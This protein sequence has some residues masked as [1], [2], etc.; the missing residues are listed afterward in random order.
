MNKKYLSVLTALLIFVIVSHTGHQARAGNSMLTIDKHVLEAANILTR[1]IREFTR[2]GVPGPLQV[3]SKKAVPVIMDNNDQAV[4]AL[5]SYGKGFAIAMGHNAWL[6]KKMLN[7]KS[8][9]QFIQNCISLSRSR[10]PRIL[11]FNADHLYNSLKKT[12]RVYKTK[13]LPKKLSSYKVIFSIIPTR[14]ENFFQESEVSRIRKW[15]SRGGVFVGASIGWVFR[16]YGPGKKGKNITEDFIANKLFI[17]MGIKYKP[18]YAKGRN[19][20]VQPVSSYNKRIKKAHSGLFIDE[21]MQNIIKNKRYKNHTEART[22]IKKIFNQLNG[23][24]TVKWLLSDKEIKK[25]TRLF[26]KEKGKIFPTLKN[27]IDILNARQTGLILLMDRILRS[28]NYK[29]KAI[30]A[31]CRD[32]PGIAAESKSI[33]KD[34]TIDMSIPRWH[35]TGLWV[36]PYDKINISV[37]GQAVSKGL[38]IRIGCHKDNLFLSKRINIWERWPNISKSVALKSENNIVSSPYGGLI[39]IDV[40]VKL[41]GKVIVTIK[42]AAPAPLYTI[43]ETTKE[44]WQSQLKSTSSPIGEIQGKYVII[45][46]S[47][48]ALKK[49]YD[50]EQIARFWDSAILSIY[51]LA[52]TEPNPCPERYVI[53]QQLIA[54]YMHNGYPMV[55]SYKPDMDRYVLGFET[56]RGRLLEEGSWGHFHE[57]GHNNQ[58]P[59]WTFSGTVEVTVN[60][61][62]LY[63]MEK[64]MGIK[65]LEHKC[66]KKAMERKQKYIARGSRFSEWKK[67]P[68]L[69]LLMYIELQQKFGW[70][71][72]KKV[73]RLYNGLSKSERPKND[74]Q[75]R[76]QW[77]LRYSLAVDHDLTDFFESWGLPFDK[78][79]KSK[80]RHLPKWNGN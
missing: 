24:P 29:N 35:S 74:S 46:T 17:P 55:T 6:Q 5:S 80:L 25:I 59:D 65:P 23:V 20:S 22:K 50:P 10:R 38:K 36:N 39:Y 41:K 73:F 13:K 47:T 14:G 18:G 28:T 61:F 75:K 12:R 77:V 37:P 40:P 34:V 76:D 31:I 15:I 8:T 27:P 54:G 16:Y 56:R 68:I 43:G 51:D 71:S 1:E 3:F 9:Q 44:N 26:L 72:Y 79:I 49:D 2:E 52:Q 11:T 63:T 53:D 58:N 32:F 62:T 42:G 57:A 4:V 48:R 30:L 45:E 67:D 19:Y 66:V 64:I 69:G 70:D 78:K 33:K 7:D 21:L 60:L